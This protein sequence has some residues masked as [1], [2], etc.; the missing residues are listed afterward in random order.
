MLIDGDQTTN[1]IVENLL[2]TTCSLRQEQVDHL[3]FLAHMFMSELLV[4]RAIERTFGFVTRICLSIS[5]C[6]LPEQVI[7]QSADMLR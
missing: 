4:V 2:H 7:D 5:L 6:D 1:G 3:G